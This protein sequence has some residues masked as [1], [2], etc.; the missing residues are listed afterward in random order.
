MEEIWIN[1]IRNVGDLEVFFDLIE[2]VIIFFNFFIIIGKDLMIVSEVIVISF[3]LEEDVL[4]M[5]E[6]LD[7]FVVEEEE[8]DDYVELKVEGSFIEEVNLF[9][10]FKD[11][12]LF[13]VVLEVSEKLDM[14]GDDYKLVF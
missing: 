10:E 6:F 7:K 8:D 3:F 5:L 1:E 9:I 4:E 11:N 2:V 12:S 14:F 13:L